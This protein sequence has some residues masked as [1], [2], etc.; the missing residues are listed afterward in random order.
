MNAYTSS[1]S[2]N[3]SVLVC[4][5]GKLRRI[6]INAKSCK[7]SLEPVPTFSANINYK[8]ESGKTYRV[9]VESIKGI[10]Y[11][12][13][14]NVFVYNGNGQKLLAKRENVDLR[15]GKNIFV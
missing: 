4:S 1:H 13:K 7:K 15:F 3:P 2:K 10:G 9:R 6:D 11:P 5:A 14:C 8:D 12:T